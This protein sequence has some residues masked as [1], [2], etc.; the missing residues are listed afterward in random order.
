LAKKGREATLTNGNDGQG[1]PAQR[2]AAYAVIGAVIGAVVVWFVAD[3]VS[4]ATLGS[5]LIGGAVAGTVAG[6]VRSRAGLDQ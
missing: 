5:G 4:F 1:T 6:F 2:Y 3:A